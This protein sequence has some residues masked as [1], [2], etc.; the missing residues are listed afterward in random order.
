MVNIIRKNT[1][2]IKYIYVIKD[3]SHWS[4]ATGNEWRAVLL[5]FLNDS[6][7]ML[8]NYRIIREVTFLLF[9]QVIDFKGLFTVFFSKVWKVCTK[10][11]NLS[12]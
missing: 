11:G 2:D 12:Y 8:T 10:C 5:S 3:N 6:T 9:L 4:L 7:H 1:K